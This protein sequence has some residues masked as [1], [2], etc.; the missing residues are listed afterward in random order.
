M[1]SQFAPPEGGDRRQPSTVRGWLRKWGG[2]LSSNEELRR[3]V[4]FLLLCF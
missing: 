3:R 4:S 1:E 2:T